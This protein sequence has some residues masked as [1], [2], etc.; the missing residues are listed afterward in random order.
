MALQFLFEAAPWLQGA[1]K[2][3]LSAATVGVVLV[4]V[5]LALLYLH[6]SKSNEQ[7]TRKIH[8]L[9]GTL[10]ILGN[11]VVFFR[12][13]SRRHE[14]FTSLVNHYKG[15]PF[16]IKWFGNPPRVL[17]STV[18]AYEE[19]L[20]T[21]FDNFP[22]GP[23]Q[24]EI[25][26]DVLGEGIFASDNGKW[27][28]QRKTAVNLFTA[29]A[30]RETMAETMRK[31]THVL[32]DIFDRTSENDTTLDLVKIL[33]RFTIEAF[34]EIGFGIEMNCLDAKEE[35]PLQSAFDRAQRL[36]ALR[37]Q[38]P[39]AFWKLQRLLGVGAEKQLK[40][41]VKVIDEAVFDIISKALANRHTRKTSE[42]PNLVSIFLDRADN[43]QDEE[44]NIDPV[45]LRDMVVN[46]MFAGRDTTA[47]AMSWFFVSLSTRPD[48]GE[49]IRKEIS[50]VIPELATGKIKVPTMEQVQQ[51]TFLDAAI[52]ESLRLYPAVPA[53]PKFIEKDTLLSDG[54]FLRRGSVAVLP[55]YAF[56][57]AKH[58]W[59]ED[60]ADY[61]PERWIDE[62]TGKV[63]NESSF[64][65]ASFNAGP[66]ICLGMNLA[67]LEMKIVLASLLSRYQI[68]LVPGQTITYDNALTL[69]IKGEMN[70]SVKKLHRPLVGDK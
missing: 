41:D 3:T 51:L 5:V 40:E 52:K 38:R 45:F 25:L 56:A 62:T 28:H 2:T 12:N 11:T 67:M 33:S 39:P 17:L 8:K 16:T 48:V 57:R 46:F 19:V 55:T 58:V 63:R 6:K 43:A 20:K 42:T 21:K 27:A 50:A 26:R 61:K 30:L 66:R 36:S 49:K 29:R 22:K 44:R 13:I 65:F 34:A 37:Y 64:K 7:G 59:G 68:D 53:I 1:D 70:V 9:P 23:K 32:L 31:Y 60:A 54:T 14:W 69:A 18:E 10:P 35:H 47:Q 15:E 24:I 4:P